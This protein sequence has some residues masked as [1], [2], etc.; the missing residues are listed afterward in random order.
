M[1]PFC[2]SEVC[3]PHIDNAHWLSNLEATHWLDHI[4]CVLSGALRIADKVESHKTSV[5]VHCSDGWDRTAQVRKPAGMWGA[6]RKGRELLKKYWDKDCT[7]TNTPNG[8]VFPLFS[9]LTALSMLM[10]DGFYRTISG[11]AVLLEKEWLSFGH[12]FAQVSCIGK[13]KNLLV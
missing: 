2:S 13:N 11:F 6:V 4:R 9:Q 7:H 1:P 8:M 5:V 12:K 10:L 3:Y